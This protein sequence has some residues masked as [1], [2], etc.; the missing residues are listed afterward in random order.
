MTALSSSTHAHVNQLWFMCFSCGR[1]KCYGHGVQYECSECGWRVKAVVTTGLVQA[2]DVSDEE[3]LQ[4]AEAWRQKRRE[5]QTRWIARRRRVHVPHRPE[6]KQQTSR[7]WPWDDD[8]EALRHRTAANRKEQMEQ[9]VLVVKL[10][11]LRSL[12]CQHGRVWTSAQ[13]QAEGQLDESRH[14][15]ITATDEELHADVCR[16][17]A[18]WSVHA[19]RNH[20]RARS[21][22][23]DLLRQEYGNPF[24]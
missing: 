24:H 19:R 10:D 21:T 2:V 9:P 14:S 16:T 12:P 13:E 7:Q 23:A 3:M 17:R 20:R 11:D 4:S 5:Y 18:S 15:L 22:R 8:C 6:A 1:G